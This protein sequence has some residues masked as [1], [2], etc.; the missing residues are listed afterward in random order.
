M[1]QGGFPG[2]REILLLFFFNWSKTA[3]H[4]VLV[5]T[6]KQLESAICKHMPLPS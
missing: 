4:V 3:L 1:S 5:S 6:V 2:R